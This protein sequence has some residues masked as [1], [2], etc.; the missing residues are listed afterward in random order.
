MYTN[1]ST[2]YTGISWTETKSTGPLLWLTAYLI[3]VS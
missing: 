2:M 1:S 3:A